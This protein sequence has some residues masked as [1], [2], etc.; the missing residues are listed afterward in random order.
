[1]RQTISGMVVGG[2]GDG[3]VFPVMGRTGRSTL[4]CLTCLLIGGF[5]I[6]R[7]IFS[8]F[9]LQS[10]LVGSSLVVCSLF[11]GRP[12]MIKQRLTL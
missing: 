7:T 8:N 3:A 4:S 2:H 5:V 1:V 6:G 12:A 9:S 11:D 10:I